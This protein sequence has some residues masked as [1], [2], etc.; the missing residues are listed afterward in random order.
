MNTHSQFMTDQVEKFYQTFPYPSYPLF[1]RPRYQE[2]FL[3]SSSFNSALASDVHAYPCGV[4]AQDFANKTKRVLVLGCGDT[5][6]YVFKSME[7]K[8]H[9]LYFVDL[10]KKNLIR[11][12]IRSSMTP[13]HATW[14]HADLVDFLHRNSTQGSLNKFAHVEAYGVVHHLSDPSLAL[15]LISQNM[16]KHGTLRLMVYNSQARN[17]IHSIQSLFKSCRLSPYNPK[18]LALAKSLLKK[19]STS[20]LFKRELSGLGPSILNNNSRLVDTFFH[21]RELSWSIQLWFDAIKRARLHVY[22]LFDR[23]CELDD[24]KNPLSYCPTPTQLS[25]R[26]LDKRFENNLELFICKTPLQE[27]KGYFERKAK[28][29]FKFRLSPPPRIFFN[30]PETKDL[31]FSHKWFLWNNFLSYIHTGF[32]LKQFDDVIDKISMTSLKRLLRNGAILPGMIKDSSLLTEMNAPIHSK[33]T[34]PA[35]H[36]LQD[37]PDHLTQDIKKIL[38]MKN[39]DPKNLPKLINSLLNS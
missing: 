16:C 26:A 7:P 10:A 33:M 22:G 36:P 12:K 24:L 23:Y 13:H 4:H 19:I 11:A 31:K 3:S 35:I 37:L 17:W 18:D 5:Q 1:F 21:V 2:A 29:H 38:I 30:D 6:P 39:I 28:N 32:H 14:I 15:E 8:T 9:Q 34:P 27:H 20:P 25:E